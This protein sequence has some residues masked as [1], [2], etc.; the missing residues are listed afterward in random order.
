MTATIGTSTAGVDWSALKADL[1][2][3]EFDNGRDPSELAAS[4]D[5][6]QAVA[7]A[8][9]GGRVVG[10]ARL[11]S[12][13]VCNAL[14]VDVWTLRAH[15]RQGIASAMVRS[16]LAAV[17]GQHVTLLTEHAEALYESVGFRR[18]DI[19]MSIVVGNWLRRP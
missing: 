14:L 1:R 15:R 4:F 3:D 8:W 19:G 12:D 7:F 18:Q 17:P 10:T 9:E 16:L 11:L 6:S 13:G 2:T 5:A